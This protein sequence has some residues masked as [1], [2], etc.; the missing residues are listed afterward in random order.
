MA[1]SV[2]NTDAVQAAASYP[3]MDSVRKPAAQPFNS[4]GGGGT[5]RPAATKQSTGVYQVGRNRI[6]DTALQ[7]SEDK[8]RAVFQNANDAIMLYRLRA[9]GTPECFIEVNDVACQ[10]LK[11]DRDELLT[12]VP[13]DLDAPEYAAEKERIRRLLCDQQQ[14]KFDIEVITKSGRRVPVEINSHR[15]TLNSETVVLSVIR[16]A[17]E[18]KRAEQAMAHRLT[19]EKAVARVASLLVAR[20]GV[21]LRQVVEI[22][23]RAVGASRTYIFHYR[24][25]LRYADKLCEWCADGVLPQLA[26]MQNVPQTEYRWFVGK[27]LRNES[28]VVSDITN[29][30]PE[31]RLEQRLY[32][33]LG[34]CA[35]LCVPIYADGSL[36]GTLG[37]VD[38]QKKRCW[39]EDDVRILRTVS[40]LIGVYVERENAEAELQQYINTLQHTQNVLREKEKLALVG[41]MAAG[42][43]HE[44]KNP[45]TSVRGF[46]QLMKDRCVADKG[47]ALDYL[48]IILE[49]VDRASGVISDFL[50]LA[51]PKEPVLEQHSLN[52]LLEEVMDLVE[53]QAFLQH[54]TVRCEAAAGLPF[55]WLDPQQIKQVLLNMCQNAIEAMPAGGEIALRTAYSPAG[56]EIVFEVRDTGS[57]I[58]AENM[59]K[60]GLPFYTTKENG[61][62]LGLSV[63]Y[64][65][66]R[67]HGGRTEVVSREG[68]G[69]IFRVYLPEGR[70]KCK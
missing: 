48:E 21:D 6:I 46:A 56:R 44:V 59:D 66:I 24:E 28:V 51:R 47:L 9:D 68:R 53:P 29:M 2:N 3:G 4:T 15:F 61:T 33:S 1:K 62:G 36:W 30:P 60:I 5:G 55:C 43:A 70:P 19:V 58:A 25:N 35:I 13:A 63:S 69:T 27:I 57:G 45:L 22:L 38:T 8:Y 41:Q 40:E 37:F 39:S 42:M 12:M 49:E 31:A 18:R 17:T 54:C 67:A 65:I 34:I 7:E 64:S 10:M 16:D 11:Y 20:T 23:G 50:Q 52:S 14:A 26:S 32:L